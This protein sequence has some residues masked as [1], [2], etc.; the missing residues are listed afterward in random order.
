M[1]LAA[2]VGLSLLLVDPL[3]SAARVVRVRPG[4]DG[5]VPSIRRAVATASAGDTILLANGTYTGEGNRD[6]RVGPLSLTIR[7]ISGNPDSCIIDCGTLGRGF[8]FEVSPLSN[9]GRRGALRLEGVTITNGRAETGGAIECGPHSC[10]TIINCVLRG[11]R[12]EEQGGGVHCELTDRP[13]FSHCIIAGN[14]AGKSGGGFA[15]CCC[16]D[17]AIEDCTIVGNVAPEGSAFAGGLSGTFITRSIIAFH[18]LSTTFQCGYPCSKPVTQCDVYGNF[19]GDGKACIGFKP[20]VDGN[21]SVDPG[22]RDLEGMD[23]R[24]LPDSPL[25]QSPDGAA[26]GIGARVE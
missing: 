19:G 25:R 21:V 4:G 20:G 23:F 6:I 11:N 10:P 15:L 13:T 18:R 7:S 9:G 16:A 8:H 24:L 17:A 2:L 14:E 26:R 12:A 5:D 1:R 3:P 22:F